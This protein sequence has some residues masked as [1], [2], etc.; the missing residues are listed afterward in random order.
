MKA[1]I[2]IDGK[3]FQLSPL[4]TPSI[5]VEIMDL[6]AEFLAN[7]TRLRLGQ[8]ALEAM[9][10]T[11]D[12][13]RAFLMRVLLLSIKELQPNYSG[14]EISTLSSEELCRTVRR[15]LL[16]EPLQNKSN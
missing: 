16:L 15:I 1:E 6:Q 7:L 9:G 12:S 10:R 8:D 4:T 13:I 14:A 5:S 11:M 2:T 3:V